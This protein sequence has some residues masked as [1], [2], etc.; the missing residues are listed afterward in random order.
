MGQR[1]W[2]VVGGQLLVVLG[3]FL[4]GDNGDRAPLRDLEVRRL[5]LRQAGGPLHRQ[6]DPRRLPRQLATWSAG[7]GGTRSASPS[8]SSLLSIVA[9][10]VLTFA[11][12][13]TSLPL[14]WINL[15]GSLIFSLLIP[16]VAIGETLL[17]FDLQARAEAEPAKPRRSWRP[18]RPRQFGRVVADPAPQPATS[19]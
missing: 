1:F 9:G 17:Y 5:E 6:V 2:R 7:A 3:I 15:L 10:P 14:L 16:Y 19:G 13:F 12:I 11:L 4:H 8:S 18:W